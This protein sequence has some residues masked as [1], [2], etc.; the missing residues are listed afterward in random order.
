MA[1]RAFRVIDGNGQVDDD[2]AVLP[3]DYALLEEEVRRQRR[4]IAGYKAQIAKLQREDPQ[5]PV[6]EGVLAYWK[7]ACHGA[8]SRV[9][10]PLDGKRADVVRKTVKRL[11]DN[12]PD[13]ELANPDKTAQ[14]EAVNAAVERAVE[15]IKLAIDGA[16]RM[17]FE[18]S[19]GARFAEAGKGRKRKVDIVYVCRDEIKLEQFVAL[20]D[21]EPKRLAYR[22]TLAERL[23]S[24]PNLKLVLASLFM[25]GECHGEILARAVRYCAS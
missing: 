14:G 15:R 12:D 2:T 7:R 16:A 4:V 11:V 3:R 1:E 22:A 21:A 23:Q 24:E 8:G 6:I 25:D 9:E 5:A 17:P 19:Y 13:P 10:I 20:V 18:G